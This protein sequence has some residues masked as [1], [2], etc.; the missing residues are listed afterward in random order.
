MI[1]QIN[2]FKS[3]INTLILK[4]YKML[5]WNK[6]KSKNQIQNSSIIVMLPVGPSHC[7]VLWNIKCSLLG[8]LRDQK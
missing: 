7:A 1:F 6:N 8:L 4:H 5:D 3:N 2:M